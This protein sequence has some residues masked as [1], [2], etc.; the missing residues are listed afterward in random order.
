MYPY[1]KS[2]G[3]PGCS[4]V[5]CVCLVCSCALFS[6]LMRGH[7]KLFR[8]GKGIWVLELTQEDLLNNHNN[9]NNSNFKLKKNLHMHINILGILKP[10]SWKKAAHLEKKR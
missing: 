10:V 7:G 1:C 2:T 8:T 6:I 3:E 5:S 4:V 9:N